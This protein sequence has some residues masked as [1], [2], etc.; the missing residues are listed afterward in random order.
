MT[1][2]KANL[3]DLPVLVTGGS[4]FV[5]SHLASRLAAAGARVRALVRRRG[6]YPGLSSSNVSQMEGDFVD[7]ETARRACE[8]M[9]LVVHSAATIGS[10]LAEARRVN[11]GGTAALAAAAREAGCRRFIHVSTIS[12]YDWERGG[13]VVDETAPLK[14]IE[15]AYPHTPAASPHYGLSKAE[16]RYHTLVEQIQFALQL[17][18]VDFEVMRISEAEL[19]ATRSSE[20][21]GLITFDS[22]SLTIMVKV[23]AETGGTIRLDGWLT[24]PAGHPIEIRTANGP[25]GT[26]S[27]ADGRFAVGGVPHGMVQVV[28]RTPGLAVSTPAVEL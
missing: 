4:G 11:A 12:V 28:V 23:T 16:A 13:S 27:D 8:G 9:E 22:D 7:P 20:Q 1:S 3:Q 26:N 24:P 10:D 19:A 6:E 17:E 18:D 2:I 5:G 15:K 25:K 14:T 21:G